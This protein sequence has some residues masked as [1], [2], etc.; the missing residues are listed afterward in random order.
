MQKQKAVAIRLQDWILHGPQ[1]SAA[2]IQA[3]ILQGRGLL[4]ATGAC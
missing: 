2:A 1:I 3:E 4:E